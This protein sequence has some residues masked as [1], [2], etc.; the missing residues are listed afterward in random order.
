MASKAPCAERSLSG[1]TVSTEAGSV[2]RLS[3]LP[4]RRRPPRARLSRTRR[5][6]TSCRSSERDVSGR[7]PALRRRSCS[8]RDP[9]RRRRLGRSPSDRQNP[10]AS[11][12]S[13]PG[14]RIVTATGSPVDADLERLL[15]RDQVLRRPAGDTGQL[16]AS[17]AVRRR[18]GRRRASRKTRRRRAPGRRPVDERRHDGLELVECGLVREPPVGAEARRRVSER[19]LGVDAR[20]R[21]CAPG[22]GARRPAPRR[23]RTRPG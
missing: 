20:A 13:W 21:R 6:T 18:R 11:S 5:T 17:G 14:V 23:H 12:S 3:T 1:S 7:S 8:R 9:R 22:S 15:D 10:S 2:S 16:D 19:Q 4:P